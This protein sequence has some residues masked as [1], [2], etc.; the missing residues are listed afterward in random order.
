MPFSLLKSVRDTVSQ[1]V[2]KQARRVTEYLPERLQRPVKAARG[3]LAG[4]TLE[5]ARKY[6]THLRHRKEYNELQS[7]MRDFQYFVSILIARD[8]G[9]FEA[10]N[11][12]PA[13]AEVLA[14]RCDVHP[15][16]METVLRVLESRD[17]VKREDELFALSSFGS[18][19]LAPGGLLSI[20]P[21]LEFLSS[22]TAS[23]DDVVEGTRTGQIP[24]KLD[25]FSDEAN[26]EAYLEAVNFY[27]DLAGRDF[28]TQ[29]DLPEI[30]NFI[31]GSMGV[32]FSSLILNEYPGAEVTYGCLDHLVDHIPALR[33]EYNIDP[34]RVKG[35]HRHSGEPDGDKWGE[36][37]FDLVFLTKKML[38]EPED[39]M[40]EKF[41]RKAYDVLNPGGVVLFWET[42]HPD[43]EATPF[44]RAASGILDL[45]ASPNGFTLTE[46]A[47]E[48]LLTR[49]GFDDVEYVYALDEECSFALAR[50]Q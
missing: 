16:A 13:A 11:N 18:E 42:I 6:L 7:A 26:Y 19:F 30:E 2:S 39:R 10:L 46:D 15:R 23:Y 17:I 38:L 50:K 4:D 41:A 36:E 14:N 25:V 44:A 43:N 34:N 20:D 5:T 35:M 31:V 3:I 12:R 24:P 32:S 1:Q 22:F 21:M 40:G 49:I 27:L 48:D 47:F 9:V 45:A 28:L 29:V 33:M 37:S 8:L